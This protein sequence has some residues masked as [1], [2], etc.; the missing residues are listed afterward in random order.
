MN[1]LGSFILGIGIN[2]V[3]Y[4]TILHVSEDNNEKRFPNDFWYQDRKFLIKD[5]SFSK[6]IVVLERKPKWSLY[7]TE[8]RL[9]YVLIKRKILQ[10][11]SFNGLRIE[12]ISDSRN[13]VYFLNEHEDTT[14][15]YLVRSLKRKF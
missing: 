3:H 13:L 10:S 5:K 6:E 11:I 9:R 4:L 7:L 1:D 15:P 12:Y 14:F 2:L 8:K